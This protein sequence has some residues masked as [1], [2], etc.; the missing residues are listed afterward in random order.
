M[1]P[2]ERI[3]FYTSLVVFLISGVLL[4]NSVNNQF[5]IE[6]PGYGG[7]FTEGVIGSPRFINP[8]LAISDTDK[9]LVAL[10]FSSLFRI[11]R[12]GDLKEYIVESYELSEDQTIYDIKIRQDIYFHDGKNLTVE[13]IIFTLEKIVDP[14]I[15]S[16]KKNNF[17]GVLFEKINDYEIRFTLA[18]P[19]SPFIKNLNFGILPKHIWS[20]IS[21][22]E[23]PFSESNINPIGSG[24]YKV[25][26][27]TKNSSGIPTVINLRSWK[28]HEEGRAKIAN[29]IF[30]FFQNENDLIKA[31]NNKDID[32]TSGLSLKTIKESLYNNENIE[33]STL[34]RVFGVFFN[35][36]NAPLFLNKEV[37]EALDI[38]SPRELIIEEVLYGFG[39]PISGPLPSMI[40]E[41]VRSKE[42]GVAMARE[43]LDKQGWEIN[44]ETGVLEKEKGDEKIRLSFSI[45]TS[46]S[47][48]LKKVAQ[49]LVD[50]WREIGA[51]VDVKVFDQTDLSQNI[52]KTRRYDALLFGKVIYDESD[53]YPFWHSS[54]RNDPGL[55]ISLY[56]NI[57]SDKELEKIQTNIDKTII[58][59]SANKVLQ[60]IKK[61]IPSIFLFSPKSVYIK[62]DKIKSVTTPEVGSVSERF[63]DIGN[64][65]IETDKIWSFLKND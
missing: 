48:D 31:F 55:N 4:I 20:N 61:D 58:K 37:R 25:F 14:V 26:K 45:T 41:E 62:N 56:A 54:Q 44:E 22:E 1:N 21:S 43:I 39:N 19:Y 28:R 40:K 35:Q 23:F 8:V 17:D 51:E 49:I 64:W 57:T 11:D 5:L 50:T 7:S 36:N 12:N 38:S 15:K 65:Y 52:I 47:D 63:V 2:T 16:P 34:P 29:I 3:L 32:N 42:E 9:D 30:K 60:E 24:P 59:E 18:K 33:T 46:D 53:L 6:V 13:D 27:V 10:V